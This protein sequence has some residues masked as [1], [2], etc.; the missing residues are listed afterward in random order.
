MS[1]ELPAEEYELMTLYGTHAKEANMQRFP[2]HYGV[3]KTESIRGSSS[4]QHQ[5]FLAALKPETNEC[6]GD[7]WA[8]H[9][10]YSGNFLAQVE[11]DQFGNVRAQIG[12]IRTALNGN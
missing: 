1:L 2:I 4:P 6:S 10:V 7:V 12:I 5:P 8:A 3:Q 9:L 11:K